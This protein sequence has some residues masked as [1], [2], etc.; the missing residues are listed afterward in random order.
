MAKR[1]PTILLI[2]CLVLGTA[3]SCDN[4]VADTHTGRLVVNVRN[5]SAP[6]PDSEVLIDVWSLSDVEPTKVVTIPN[7]EKNERF[8][9]GGLAVGQY[10]IHVYERASDG[11][12]RTIANDTVDVVKKRDAITSIGWF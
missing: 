6:A 4:S 5:I 7:V 1:I 9:V 3:V 12:C 2:L 8:A 10:G 11:T